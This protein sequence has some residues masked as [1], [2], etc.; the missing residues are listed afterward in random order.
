M[1]LSV[2]ASAPVSVSVSVYD[3]SPLALSTGLLAT[4]S[5]VGFI[6]AGFVLWSNGNTNGGY[7][8]VGIAI[9]LP[10]VVAALVHAVRAWRSQ[11]FTNAHRASLLWLGALSWLG[12]IVCGFVLWSFGNTNG[13]YSMVGIATILPFAVAAV[14][15][16]LNYYR[17]LYVT[18]KHLAYATQPLLTMSWAGFIVSGFMLWYYGNT[19]GGYSM[20]GIAIC[21]PAAVATAVLLH[22]LCSRNSFSAD[23]VSTLTWLGSLSWSGFLVAGFMLWYFGNTN[24]G[25]SMVGI[26]IILP[27]VVALLLTFVGTH[28]TKALPAAAAAAA[29]SV[30][31]PAAAPTAVVVDASVTV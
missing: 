6:V 22:T 24:G 10:A 15:G 31:A 17:P 23:V 16:A 8:M 20:V 4:L 2:S 1:S 18:A 14:L 28:G 30:A 27:A 29:V 19:N 21:L 26:A 12:F 25:Y 7:S 13:G 11:T 3:M 9:C 5:W